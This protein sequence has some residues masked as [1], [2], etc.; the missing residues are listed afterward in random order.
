M[1]TAIGQQL[2]EMPGMGNLD[3]EVS[4]YIRDG[5]IIEESSSSQSI[6]TVAVVAP[7]GVVLVALPIA[8]V[9]LMIR[10]AGQKVECPDVNVMG[11]YDVD[12]SKEVLTDKY[13]QT[14]T[15]Q[16]YQEKSTSGLHAY[17]T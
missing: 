14:E 3:L 10:R 2:A 6:V 16:S 4:K 1:A 13:G 17:S 9:V 8:V 5:G 12:N 15:D 11:P 7:V